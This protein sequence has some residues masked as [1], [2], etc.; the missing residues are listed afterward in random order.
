MLYLKY[1]FPLYQRHDC[2][3]AKLSARVAKCMTTV[4][5]IYTFYELVNRTTSFYAVTFCR[6]TMTKALQL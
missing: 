2:K 1:L 5:K 3:L 4:N 6:F